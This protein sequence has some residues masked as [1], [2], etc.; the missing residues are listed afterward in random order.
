MPTGTAESR[1]GKNGKEIDNRR[2]ARARYGD[3]RNGCRF[4]RSHL[5]AS[6]RWQP[7]PAMIAAGHEAPK[8]KQRPFV[9]L[10]WL[11]TKLPRSDG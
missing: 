10:L 3:N 9:L 4:C 8:R 6:E 7:P 2:H 11:F 1:N 5:E